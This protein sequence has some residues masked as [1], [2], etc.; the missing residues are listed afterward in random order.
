MSLCAVPLACD[1]LCAAIRARR[2]RLLLLHLSDTENTCTQDSG[3]TVILSM[4]GAS[5]SPGSILLLLLL[6]VTEQK[7]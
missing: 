5:L 2:C 6:S 3:S 1:S 4:K 7:D